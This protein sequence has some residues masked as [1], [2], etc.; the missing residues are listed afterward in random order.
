MSVTRIRCVNSAALGLGRK[1][2]R[3]E[4]AGVWAELTGISEER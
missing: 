4:M 2:T 1:V 3:Q